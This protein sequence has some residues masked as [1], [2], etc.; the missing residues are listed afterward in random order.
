MHDGAA[1]RSSAWLDPSLRLPSYAL[2]GHL[3]EPVS[4]LL[5]LFHG[6]GRN[7]RKLQRANNALQSLLAPSTAACRVSLHTH[8]MSPRVELER[9]LHRATFE[10]LVMSREL[11]RHRC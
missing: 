1:V 9:I 3:N 4:L 2:A 11:R 8:D 10:S 5:F 6:L 7:W